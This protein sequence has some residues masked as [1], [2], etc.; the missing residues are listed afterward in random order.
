MSC[1]LTID[2]WACEAYV[3]PSTAKR[4]IQGEPISPENFRNLCQVLGIEEWESLIDWDKSDSTA[5][6]STALTFKPSDLS[7]KD[8][9]PSKGGLAVTGIFTSAKRFQVEISLEIFKQLLINGS[10]I[11]K[12]TGD[13]DL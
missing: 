13:P 9:L 7:A 11:I 4:F 1:C 12:N 8:E 5:V 10:V 3:S 2:T 6:D